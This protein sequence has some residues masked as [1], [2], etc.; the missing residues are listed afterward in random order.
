MN[1][2]LSLYRA[3]GG[4]VV[5]AAT[6]LVILFGAKYPFL[7]VLASGATW[8]VGKLLGVPLPDITIKALQSMP[9][10]VKTE[11]AIQTLSDESLSTADAQA[12]AITIV[13]SL[14]PPQAERLKDLVRSIHPGGDFDVQKAILDRAVSEKAKG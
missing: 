1:K 5:S 7:N 4:L 2:K 6:I 14:P 10:A 9:P 12:L 8:Y 13:N 11:A 3:V